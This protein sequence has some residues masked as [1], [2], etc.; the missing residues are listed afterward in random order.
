MELCSG[1]ELADRMLNLKSF[2]EK[3]C[4]ALAQQMLRA[5][6]YMHINGFVPLSLF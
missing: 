1:G 2:T 5:V 3:S 4:A 6:N